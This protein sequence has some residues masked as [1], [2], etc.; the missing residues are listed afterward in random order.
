MGKYRG[1]EGQSLKQ[2]K[3]IATVRSVAASTRIEGSMMSDEEVNN[4]LNNIDITKLTDRDSQEVVGYFETLDIISESY[5]DIEI[6][7]NSIKNLHKILMRHSAKDKWHKG[8][9]KQVSNAVEA[10]Y[11]DGSKHI[12]FQTTEAGLPTQDAMRLLVD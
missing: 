5:S 10:T 9:Y 12:V 3:S 4:L 11:L 7:E 6:L 1:K 2:L 8:D